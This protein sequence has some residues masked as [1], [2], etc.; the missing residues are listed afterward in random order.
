MKRV[1]LVTPQSRQTAHRYIDEAPSDW[2]VTFQ[3]RTR[4]I[5]QN[6][7]Q[8]P[9][10]QGFSQQLKWP[11]NCEMVYMSED[12]WKDVLTAAFFAETVRLAQGLNGGVVMVGKRTSK[13][14]ESQFREWMAFLKAEAANRGVEPVYANEQETAHGPL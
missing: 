9:Y 10:L 14:T 2:V 11:V 3:E 12:E 6:A 7:K 1:Y 4:T 5:E 13:F 8:W